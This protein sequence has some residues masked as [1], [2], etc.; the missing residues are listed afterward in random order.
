MSALRGDVLERAVA[1]VAIEA[2][3]LR[4]VAVGR[5]VVVLAGHRQAVD[6][7]LGACRA[8]S[9]RRTDRASRRGR[10]RRTTTTRP[11]RRDC[12]RRL[13]RHVGERAVAVVVQQH[14]AAEAGAI[15]VHEAVVVVVA[16][17][18]AHAVGLDVDAAGGGDVG[19]VQRARAVGRHREVVAVEAV[20]ERRLGWK[21][22]VLQRLVLARAS[23]PAPD[24]RRGRRRCRSRTAPTPGAMI[25]G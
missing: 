1:A 22:R 16:G 9:C 25:S 8:G 21:R 4:A 19:E 10:S 5:A 12:R 24:R 18:D 2:A 15:E 3:R 6:V 20:P 11:S 23:G 14:R 13:R 17:R 7:G